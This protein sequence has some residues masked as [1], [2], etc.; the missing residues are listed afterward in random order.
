[1]PAS[2]DIAM[3]AGFSWGRGEWPWPSAGVKGRVLVYRDVSRGKKQTQTKN[4]G[5]FTEYLG[6]GSKNKFLKQKIWEAVSFQKH[7]TN[8]AGDKLCKRRRQTHWSPIWKEGNN[9]TQLLT[10][11]GNSTGDHKVTVFMSASWL[12]WQISFSPLCGGRIQQN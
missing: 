3:K 4:H 8:A 9:V 5:R 12:P 11:S 2:G 6:L 7:L 10:W 1:M